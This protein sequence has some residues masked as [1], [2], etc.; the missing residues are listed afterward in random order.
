MS[1][2]RSIRSRGVV[3]LALAA[4][5]AFALLFALGGCGSGSATAASVTNE[6]ATASFPSGHDTDEVSVT[7]A[8]PV[9]PCALVTKREAEGIL[10]AGVKVSERLQ[11]PT[12]VYSG[13]GR[14][15]TLVVMKGSLGKLRSGAKTS[16][17]VTVGGRSG[18]CLRYEST[19]VV[20]G[21]GSGR[22]L[23]VTGPCAAGVRF[24][25]AAL[26]RLPS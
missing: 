26:R 11:G 21:A 20:V 13:S 14:E 8:K 6:I 22:V 1:A 19:S 15:V 12:C 24:A 4:A 9:K 10:G 25:A 17:P 5:A 18:Y 7:G 23:Q 16:T 2:A 3:G